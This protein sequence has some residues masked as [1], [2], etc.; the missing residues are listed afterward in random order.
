MAVCVEGTLTFIGR[1]GG[2]K[3]SVDL[4]DL[5]GN[6]ENVLMCSEY[7]KFSDLLRGFDNLS[8]YLNHETT[9]NAVIIAFH[10]SKT[11]GPN[12]CEESYG[13]SLCHRFVLSFL[14]T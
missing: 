5:F 6:T 1:T 2:I 8:C 4:F 7:S 11:L 10:Y 12:S 9:R 3:L 13:N 14:I